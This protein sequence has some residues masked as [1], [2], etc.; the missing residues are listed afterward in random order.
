MGLLCR[1]LQRDSGS[2]RLPLPEIGLEI[3]YQPQRTWFPNH[4]KS[5]FVLFFLSFSLS[6]ALFPC[7]TGWQVFQPHPAHLGTRCHCVPYPSCFPPSE[8]KAAELQKGTWWHMRGQSQLED[9]GGVGHLGA[10][11]TCRSLNPIPA[12]PT[13]PAPVPKLIPRLREGEGGLGEP[14]Q[15]MLTDMP[16]TARCYRRDP[17]L[18][19]TNSPAAAA[20]EGPGSSRPGSDASQPRWCQVAPDV[21]GW[22]ELSAK[23]VGEE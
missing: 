3:L 19:S 13:E 16:G 2:L 14:G 15:G 5:G 12:C 22:G 7:L 6:Q 8:G 21:P 17:R 4:S 9:L 18:V 1:P 10:H 20:G 11:P 23:I